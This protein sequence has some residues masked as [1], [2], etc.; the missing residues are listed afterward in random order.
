MTEIMIQFKEVPHPL[1]AQEAAQN[2][3][4]NVLTYDG[5]LHAPPLLPPAPFATS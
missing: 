1:F 2:V 3:E 5:G 4:P